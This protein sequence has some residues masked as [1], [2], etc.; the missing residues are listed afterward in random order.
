MSTGD[1]MQTLREAESSTMRE[2]SA[3]R[4]AISAMEAGGVSGVP[5]RRSGLRKA[6]VNGA[7]GRTK[8]KTRG[9]SAAQRK[10]AAA[11]M[12]AYW[13]KRKAAKS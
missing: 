1:V 3:I 12:R 8:R 10:A 13:S 7:G 2:L 6:S 4:A 9:W 11:R 5:N